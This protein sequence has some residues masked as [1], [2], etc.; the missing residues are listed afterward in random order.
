MKIGKA[1]SFAFM[2]VAIAMSALA[3]YIPG[4]VGPE[5]AARP[6]LAIAVRT[7]TEGSRFP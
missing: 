4:A 3:F 6:Q 2:C 1:L 7:E 5:V